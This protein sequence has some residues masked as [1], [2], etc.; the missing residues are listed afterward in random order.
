MHGLYK[1]SEHYFDE[2][3]K[4]GVKFREHMKRSISNLTKKLED[5]HNKHKFEE[6]EYQKYISYNK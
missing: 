3:S 5:I 4:R 2:L 6:K 1:V